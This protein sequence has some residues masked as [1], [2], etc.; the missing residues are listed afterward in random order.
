MFFLGGMKKKWNEWIGLAE[1]MVDCWFLSGKE[2]KEKGFYF[3][4]KKKERNKYIETYI[5]KKR[6][7]REINNLAWL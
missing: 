6:K 3:N 4:D 2:K 7:N 1:I 5:H